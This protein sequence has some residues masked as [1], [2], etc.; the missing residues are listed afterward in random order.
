MPVSKIG[1]YEIVREIGKGAMGI[2]YEGFDPHINR[3]VAVKTIRFDAVSD[4]ILQEDLHQ[5]FLR[6]AQSAGGLHHPNI[7]TIYEVGEEEGLL[8]IAMEFVEGR[9]LEKLLASRTKLTTEETV[10]LISRIGDALDYAHRKGIVHRDVKPGNILLDSEGHP[11]L[12]DFGIAHLPSSTI[13]QTGVSMGTPSYMAPE[14]IVGQK[15]DGRADVFSLGVILYE[16]LTL[17]KPFPGDNV[18]TIIYRIMNEDFRPLKEL[19]HGVPDSLEPVVRKALAKNPAER[20]QT[21][22][23]LVADLKQQA[24]AAGVAPADATVIV[25]PTVVPRPAS[26]SRKPLI[27]VGVMMGVVLIVA[28]ILL[29]SKK[30]TPPPPLSTE[31][32]ETQGA[33]M[34]KE[35]KAVELP[36]A[37][38]QTP[39]E[40]TASSQR[41]AVPPAEKKPQ[42]TAPPVAKPGPDSSKP[43]VKADPA[44]PKDKEEVKEKAED[45]PRPVRAIGDIKPPAPVKQVEPV[46]P[47]EARRARIQGYVIME[48]TTDSRG[49]VKDVKVLRS[50]PGL[51]EAAVA[52]VRQYLYEPVIVKG[53]PRGVI[54]STTVFF[55]L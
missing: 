6:E 9:S 52:A 18:T 30:E 8:Y 37:K 10:T 45:E 19:D 44:V 42:T 2:V 53:R 54:F 13:T 50:I 1:K 12:L 31:I 40:K 15:V 7:V 25:P 51:D 38:P 24:K 32:A 21:A 17:Q 46:Y 14:Q 23:E 4:P 29:V 28:A 22:S 33:A 16:L 48:V 20:Y 26:G 55:K 35:K 34:E 27:I 5:R 49:R 36:P 47:E 3:K 43:P 41:G 11:R 39:G